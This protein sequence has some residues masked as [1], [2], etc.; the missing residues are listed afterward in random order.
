MKKDRVRN[1]KAKTVRTRGAAGER[2][3]RRLDLTKP[4][5]PSRGKSIN[6]TSARIYDLIEFP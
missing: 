3:K 1:V 6:L 4:I 2:P 5:V